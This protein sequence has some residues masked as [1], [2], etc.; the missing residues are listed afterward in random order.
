[1]MSRVRVAAEHRKDYAGRIDIREHEAEEHVDPVVNNQHDDPRID[2]IVS[3]VVPDDDFDCFCGWW[4]TT[5][6]S[7]LCAIII[8]AMNEYGDDTWVWEPILCSEVFK[9]HTEAM[10]V[11]DRLFSKHSPT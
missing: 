1:M 7:R 10:G 11:T 4:K 6:H 3:M 2:R 9:Y 8:R 5:S